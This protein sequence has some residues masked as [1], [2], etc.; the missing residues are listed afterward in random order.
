[1]DEGCAI[2]GHTGRWK[3]GGPFTDGSKLEGVNPCQL[4]LKS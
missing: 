4:R 1:V 2:T 3:H